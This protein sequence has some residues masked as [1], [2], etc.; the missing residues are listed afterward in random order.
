MVWPKQC[1]QPSC[2]CWEFLVGGRERERARASSLAVTQHY[3]A[4]QDGGGEIGEKE[5]RED[6]GWRSGGRFSH[7]C[8]ALPFWVL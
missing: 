2:N 6:T 3:A 8:E 1:G 7:F 4:G 5:E